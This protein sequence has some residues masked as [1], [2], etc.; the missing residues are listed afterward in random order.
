MK[1]K[2]YA[3][4]IL[5]LPYLSFVES[6]GYFKF[7]NLDYEHL[8][9]LGN[10]NYYWNFFA[11]FWFIPYTILAIGLLIW[12]RNKTIEEIKTTYTRAP[13]K[14]MFLTV[15]LFGALMTIAQIT[16]IIF[17]NKDG[18]G[19]LGITAIMFFSIIIAIPASLII[20]Y[21]YVGISL[22]LYEVLQKIK[23]IR[24]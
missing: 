18:S 4:L 8:T 16:S 1:S 21:P 15:G 19:G 5:L 11:I 23:F 9:V 14:M 17:N 6:I 12:S 22:L 2:T 3:R 10:V 13:I 7:N 20:G 24:D